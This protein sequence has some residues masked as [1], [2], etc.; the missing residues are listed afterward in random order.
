M[1]KKFN[2]AYSYPE[3]K[4]LKKDLQVNNPTEEDEE[5]S[6]SSMSEASDYEEIDMKIEQPASP[7]NSSLS[8]ADKKKQK[9]LL[10]KK[11]TMIKL[12]KQNKKM[13]Q[14]HKIVIGIVLDHIKTIVN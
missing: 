7:G 5:E 2:Q 6:T 12:E 1:F 9:E 4:F 13:M 11:Q 3:S 14:N 8:K 10:Q